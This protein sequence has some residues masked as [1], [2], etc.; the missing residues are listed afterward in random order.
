MKQRRKKIYFER[1]EN[2]PAPVS[3]TV[4]R[5]VLFSDVDA[6]AI[7]WHGRYAAFFEEAANELGRK[8]GLSYGAYFEA[9][10]G[11]PIAQ[12]HIDYHAP[13]KLDEFFYVTASFIWT[14]AAR[15]NT[16]YM[17]KNE[18]GECVCTGY[19]VQLFVDLKTREAHWLMPDLIARMQERWRNGDFYDR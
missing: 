10:I 8:C 5:R 18:A 13:L 3:A 15:L 4:E 11:A 9:G 17:I 14:E 6:L 19:T 12:L 2:A 16:E 1:E 7:S